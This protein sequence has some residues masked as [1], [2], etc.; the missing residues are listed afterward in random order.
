[1]HPNS[2]DPDVTQTA[3]ACCVARVMPNATKAALRSSVTGCNL[4]HSEPAVCR[5]CT[6]VALREPGH[7]TTCSMWC[8]LS[9]EVS[10]FT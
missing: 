3:T 7:T 4:K 5:L 10:W 2:A 6:M 8:A 9:N 1:M